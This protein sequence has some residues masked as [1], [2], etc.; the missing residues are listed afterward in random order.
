VVK[1]SILE[2]LS[3][4]GFEELLLGASDYEVKLKNNEQDRIF[5]YDKPNKY[6]SDISNIIYCLLNNKLI[7]SSLTSL[8]SIIE[9]LF[10]T[11]NITL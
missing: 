3:L 4:K 2:R 1:N 9:P 10:K 11:V 6:R 8:A 7:H 5:S